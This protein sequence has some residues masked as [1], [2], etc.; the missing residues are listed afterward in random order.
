VEAT[1][2]SVLKEIRPLLYQLQPEI[3]VEKGLAEALQTRFDS[4]ERRLGIEVDYQC[5]GQV[6][7]PEDIAEAIYRAA[8][9]GSNN[10]LK[11]AAASHIDVHLQMTAQGVRLEI[12]DNGQGFDPVQVKSG[13]GLKNIRQRMEQVGGVMEISSA[14]GAGSRLVLTVELNGRLD[15]TKQKG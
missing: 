15:T 5:E 7:L 6:D 4:V 3:L 1:T 9:E 11:H 13:M 12:A 8:L 14:P 2:L 10:I